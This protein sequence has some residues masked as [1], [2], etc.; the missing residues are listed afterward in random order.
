VVPLCWLVTRCWCPPLPHLQPDL[1]LAVG[2][3][4]VARQ[5]RHTHTLAVHSPAAAAAAVA[6][7]VR[8]AA[9]LPNWLAILE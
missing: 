9:V 7:V 6:V 4:Q 8:V 3:T 1:H 5:R 2:L